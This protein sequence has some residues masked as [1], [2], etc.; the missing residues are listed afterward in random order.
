M[1]RLEEIPKGVV[2]KKSKGNSSKHKKGYQF[3]VLRKTAAEL[4]F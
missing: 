3:K 1:Q 4:Q 2:Q